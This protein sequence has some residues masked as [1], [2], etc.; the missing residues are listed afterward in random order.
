MFAQQRHQIIIEKLRDEKAVKATELMELFGVSF[1][2][3]RRDLELLE[4]GG[5]LRRVHG[6]AVL[7]K[8]DHTKEIPFNQREAAYVEE[9][10]ELA[11]IA[12]G[13]VKEGM[14]IAMD[15][16][17]TNHHLAR[18]LKSRLTRLTVV[19]NS[20]VIA[21]ELTDMPGCRIMLAGG[22][23]HNE[24][25][26]VIGELAEQFASMFHTDL[27]FMSVSGVALEEGI[28]DYGLGEVQ[29][30]KIM[31]RNAKRTIALADSSKF[32]AVSLLKVCQVQDVERIITDSGIDPEII[33]TFRSEGIEIISK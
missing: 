16:S 31:L 1:E 26:S 33:E 10:R 14:S 11:R 30:K 25:Q 2:T 9:K 32:G 20:L 27:F 23:I 3:V 21:Q 5:H 12:A 29:V 24:E 22:V 18:L 8:L 4:K 13:Y 28:T 17:T 19:T 15:T 7:S 6:G